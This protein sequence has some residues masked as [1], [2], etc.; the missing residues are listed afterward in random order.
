[1]ASYLEHMALKVKDLDWHVNFFSTYFDM[2]IIDEMGEAPERKVWL[3]GGIQMNEDVSFKGPE[4][5]ADHLGLVVENLDETLDAIYGIEGVVQLPQGRNWVQ[6]PS[7]IHLEIIQGIPEG[8]NQ[9]VN[10]TVK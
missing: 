9:A 5:R 4:G 7:G 1:M 10:L 2:P 3:R 8:I 6:I